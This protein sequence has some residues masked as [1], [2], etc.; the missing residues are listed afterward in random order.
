MSQKVNLQYEDWDPFFN[1]CDLTIHGVVYDIETNVKIENGY[2]YHEFPVLA[3]VNI[4][5]IVWA[6]DSLMSSTILQLQANTVFGSN[7]LIIAFD[8]TDEFQ[9]SKGQ[10]IESSG[11]Y[12][13]ITPSV[14]VL[15]LV[16]AEGVSGSYLKPLTDS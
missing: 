4:T 9:I 16:V 6:S 11:K 2:T 10:L 13:T 8:K 5:N 1:E 7:A 12:F 3:F 15:K 14:Y